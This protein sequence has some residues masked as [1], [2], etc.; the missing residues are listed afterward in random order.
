MET[1]AVIWAGH[2]A[3]T[4]IKVTTMAE[5]KA[6]CL[7]RAQKMNGLSI[8]ERNERSVSVIEQLAVDCLEVHYSWILA[9][10]DLKAENIEVS[11]NCVSF[12]C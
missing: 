3:V 11:T 4:G 7:V 6:M 12:G 9:R 5:R 10:C 8:D 2:L 1:G